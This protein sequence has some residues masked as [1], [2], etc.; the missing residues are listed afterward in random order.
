MV[1]QVDDSPLLIGT[2]AFAVLI[3]G[4]VYVGLTI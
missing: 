1:G 4:L 3:I 2:A